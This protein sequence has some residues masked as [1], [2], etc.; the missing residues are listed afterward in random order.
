MLLST[1]GKRGRYKFN[2]DSRC[3]EIDELSTIHKPKAKGIFCSNTMHFISSLV[4]SQL[5]RGSPNTADW[6]YSFHLL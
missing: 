5:V 3:I 1:Y 6:S 2:K 4:S